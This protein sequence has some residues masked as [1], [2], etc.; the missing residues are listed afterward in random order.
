[1]RLLAAL[2]V[3]FLS[4]SLGATPVL[5][6]ADPPRTI[7]II[8]TDDMKYSVTT[9]TAKPGE[10]LTIRLMSKGKIPKVAMAHNV[11]V[12]KLGTDILKL[13]KE[14]A[15]HRETDFIPPAMA[16]AVIAKTALAGPGEAVQVTFTVPAKPGKYPFI[17]TFA[18]HYQA[19]MKGTLVVK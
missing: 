1:M 9:I 4:A 7:T 12:L 6:A 15:P 19:G 10:K 3:V 5:T 14:G 18:G 13:L 11:V 16:N 2:S 17:C 8:G